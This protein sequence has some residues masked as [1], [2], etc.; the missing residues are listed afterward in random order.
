MRCSGAIL[1]SPRPRFS[2]GSSIRNARSYIDLHGQVQWSDVADALAK[3]PN[4]PKL[5]RFSAFEGCG[6][7]K[8]A[9]SC[10]NPK[11]L[12]HCP[13]PSHDLRKGLLNQNAYSLF[14][15]MRDVAD[16]D[17]VGWLDK[18]LDG[19]DLAPACERPIV[20]RL[21]DALLKPLGD[22]DGVRDKLLSMALADLL[23]AADAH[24]RDWVKAGGAMIAI[25]TLVHNFLHRT[26]ILRDFG[27]NHSFGAG[28]YAANGCATIIE[29]IA[30]KIDARSFNSAFPANFPRFVQHAIWRFCAESGCNRCNGR[31]I[32]DHKECQQT[33]CPVFQGCAHVPLKPAP[34]SMEAKAEAPKTGPTKTAPKAANPKRESLAGYLN[35]LL[36]EGGNIKDIMEKANIKAD[37]LKVKNLTA[38]QV[39]A[40]A[41]WRSRKGAYTVKEDTSGFIQMVPAAS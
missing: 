13:L 22:I 25:D 26:G 28:C 24:R 37:Q 8:A 16:G 35:T 3:K 29:R 31:K 6:Y 36:K 14:L 4:C 30:G 7:R 12:N 1:L 21:R 38:G 40:H 10:A 27:A 41:K 5:S 11:H 17:I 2:I 19:V 18:R 33:V 39:R 34:Q 15:F 23:L 9:H 32:D 20:L